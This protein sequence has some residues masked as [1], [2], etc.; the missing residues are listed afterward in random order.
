MFSKDLFKSFSI[1]F[2][3][4]LL[5]NVFNYVFHIAMGRLLS[6]ADYGELTALIA[7]VTILWIPFSAFGLDLTREVGRLKGLKKEEEINFLIQKYL[8]VFAI[9]GTIFFVALAIIS[10][11][12]LDF[13]KVDE[14]NLLIILASVIFMAIGSV[15]AGIINGLQLFWKTVLPNL[16]NFSTKLLFGVILVIFGFK[17]FGGAL[18]VTFGALIY[19]IIVFVVLNK[20]FKGKS[21]SYNFSLKENMIV[22][23][24]ALFCINLMNNL[25]IILVKSLF[26]ATSAGYYGAAAQIGKIIFFFTSSLTLV[27]VPISSEKK[28]KNENHYY[29]MLKTLGLGF[30]IGAVGIIFY[31]LFPALII[32]LLYGSKYLGIESLIVVTGLA[33]LFFTMSN[34]LIRYFLAV[35]RKKF[36]WILIAF[37]IIET[38]LIY[39]NSTNI[40]ESATM[41]LVST[42]G[43]TLTLLGYSIIDLSARK[44]VNKGV[45]GEY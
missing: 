28:A 23:M 7:L 18:A 1:V 16:L 13:L 21:K 12:L 33:M 22:L 19:S 15:G 43:L 20:R 27:L 30:L 31:W 10:P 44:N 42:M 17:V 39:F 41:L 29:F 45:K 25:D 4:S 5:A 6:P 40:Y 35:N 8:K 32:R 38:Y 2:F 9:L 11:F 37:V 34:A 36:V 14:V 26:D 3:G 24:L